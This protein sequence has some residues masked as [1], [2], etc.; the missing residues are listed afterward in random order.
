MK[1]TIL[2]L[3]ILLFSLPVFA[4]EDLT[5]AGIQPNTD[6]SIQTCLIQPAQLG[7]LLA[8]NSQLSNS[9]AELKGDTISKADFNSTVS[10][11]MEYYEKETIARL[12]I[13]LIIFMVLIFA[14]LALAKIKRFF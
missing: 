9:I 6:P 12:M 7:Q 13:I 3:I 10:Q 4:L 2:F 8:S 5:P 1:K 14:I 11:I